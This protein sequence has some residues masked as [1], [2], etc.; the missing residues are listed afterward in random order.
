MKN[1]S[2]DVVQR[3]KKKQATILMDS[4]TSITNKN[5]QN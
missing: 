5:K 4:M 2:Y 3:E 1:F